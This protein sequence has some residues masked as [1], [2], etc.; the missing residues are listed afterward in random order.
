MTVDARTAVP[1]AVR[2]FGVVNLD[3]YLFDFNYT[4][5]EITCVID[6][7]SGR[8]KSLTQKMII[9]VDIDLDIDLF[10]FSANLIEAHGTVINKLEY[11]DFI[12]D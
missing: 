7:E 8:I 5:N 11:T 9:K 12:W 2:L 10:F 1:S 4:G 3:D 6:R